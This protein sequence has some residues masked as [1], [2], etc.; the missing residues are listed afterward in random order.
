MARGPVVSSMG[1][2]PCVS[3][4]IQRIFLLLLGHNG[5]FHHQWYAVL[6]SSLHL[7]KFVLA[8]PT[9]ECVTRA[10]EVMTRGVGGPLFGFA[11][12]LGGAMSQAIS[13]WG[14]LGLPP[15][16]QP[17]PPKTLV[18]QPCGQRKLSSVVFHRQTSALINLPSAI[19]RRSSYA[20]SGLG[21]RSQV[22]PACS[23]AGA[24][25]SLCAMSSSLTLR[26]L[27]VFPTP[28]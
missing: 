16:F 22:T 15:L 14:F 2:G 26:R 25:R 13:I 24:S 10:W 12:A 21:T 6:S 19:V 7:R 4:C 28:T 20:G 18:S 3:T 23:S 11:S 27:L 8:A 5:R 17:T 1:R 9:S